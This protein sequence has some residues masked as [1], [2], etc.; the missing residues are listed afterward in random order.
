MFDA[1]QKEIA[2]ARQLAL[3]PVPEN[4]QE[5]NGKLQFLADYLAQ[6]IASPDREWLAEQST[7][8]LVRRLPSEMARL[9]D[10]MQAP[11]QFYAGLAFIHAQHFGSYERSGALRCLQPK[12]SGETVVHL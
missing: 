6:R 9:R 3:D 8:Q 5:I 12:P 7:Q 4:Y 1:V 11:L 10:L 2:E